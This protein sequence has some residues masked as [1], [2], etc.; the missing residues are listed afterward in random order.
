MNKKL[1]VV[2]VVLI[3]LLLVLILR[4]AYSKYANHAIAVKL[5]RIGQW[6]IKVNEQDITGAVNTFTIDDFTWDWDSAPNVKEPKVAPGMKGKFSIKIDPTG[7]DVSLKYTI[8]IDENKLAEI[9][10]I[11]LNITGLVENGVEK[12]LTINDEGELVIEKIVEYKDIE[13]GN[14]I[15][16]L[17]IEVTW[18]DENTEE[19]NENDS[20]V[21]SVAN[22][23]IQ[24]PVEI[25]VIQYMPEVP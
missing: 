3:L 25:H 21:G 18:E 11:N 23:T 12:E 4:S 5:S 24:M 15:D 9:A 2:I 20:L 16:N 8:K 10:D 22:T 19:S 7:T 13:A 1:K 6:V 14:A 17:E